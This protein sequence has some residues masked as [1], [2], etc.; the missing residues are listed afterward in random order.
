MQDREERELICEIGRRMYDKDLIAANEGN[1]SIRLG[2]RLLATPTGMCKG[3]MQPDDLVYTD[4]QGKQVGGRRKVS[5][6]IL[7]HSVVYRRRPDVKA[8]CHG[9]PVYA[10]AHAVAGIP[11]TEALMAEVVVTL[12]CVPVAPYGTPST[13][14]L[15]ESLEGLVEKHD[16]ILLSNHGALTLGHDLEQ[17]FFRMEILEHYAKIAILT[18]VLGRQSLLKREQVDRLFDLRSK[19]GISGADSDL[20]C[21][22][23]SDDS[24]QSVHLSR[25]ELEDLIETAVRQ[26]AERLSSN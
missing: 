24:D 1:L 9:H 5:S 7:M 25:S 21:A 18:K 10:T 22:I 14:E 12:G 6:E 20:G 13:A 26:V 23:T 11:L 4:L 3:F 8:V 16:A 15:A 2:D 19:Y 17:A